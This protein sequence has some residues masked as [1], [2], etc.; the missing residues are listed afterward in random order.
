MYNSLTEV[1]IDVKRAK[2]AGEPLAADT[3]MALVNMGY[4][5]EVVYN[6]S[7]NNISNSF[8]KEMTDNG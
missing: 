5:P 6:E 4:D 1:I 2:D 3:F 7:I 8:I